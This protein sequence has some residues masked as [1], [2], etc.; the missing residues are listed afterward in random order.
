MLNASIAKM[1]VDSPMP[2][3]AVTLESVKDRL[4]R[5]HKAAKRAD[6]LS[7]ALFDK[8]MAEA[9]TLGKGQPVERQAAMQVRTAI[10]LE[11]AA[12]RR[13][14]PEHIEGLPDA[15]AGRPRRPCRTLMLSLL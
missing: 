5:A 8:W 4:R 1:T 3:I 7:G 11:I 6:S 10:M 14:W 13:G 2:K 15:A 9:L 12:E